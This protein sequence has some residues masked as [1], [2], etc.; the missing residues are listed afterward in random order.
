ADADRR[1]PALALVGRGR[2]VDAAVVDV[3]PGH[4]DVAARVDG[5]RREEMPRAA[6]ARGDRE[7]HV[8]ELDPRPLAGRH[9]ADRYAHVVAFVAGGVQVAVLRVEAQLAAGRVRGE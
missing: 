3:D 9:V 4:V 2:V 7:R 8:V 6:A 5:Q 1:R